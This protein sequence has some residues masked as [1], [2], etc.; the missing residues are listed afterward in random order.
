MATRPLID[1]DSLLTCPACSGTNI[2]VDQIFVSARDEDQAADE[3]VVNAM[4]GQ[5]SSRGRGEAPTGAVV[6]VGRR[7][8]IALAG[9]CEICHEPLALV[10]TQHKGQTL[11][12]WSEEAT[13]LDDDRSHD[14]F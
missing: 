7:H 12:E 8:R 2:H 4:S 6:G 11:V 13:W 9:C 3:I 14:E 1:A 10:F 5:V